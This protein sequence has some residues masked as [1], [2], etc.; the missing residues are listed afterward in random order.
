LAA[1]F[2]P[3]L[4]VAW[5]PGTGRT[6]RS[7]QSEPNLLKALN[8]SCGLSALP[9]QPISN[10]EGWIPGPTAPPALLHDFSWL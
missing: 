5:V 9:A 3:S 7:S 1:R 10:G 4:G 8:G 6:W 2:Q